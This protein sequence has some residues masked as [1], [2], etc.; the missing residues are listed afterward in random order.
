MVV[1]P[2][3]TLDNLDGDAAVL[4]LAEP[5]YT[6]TPAVDGTSSIAPLPLI[7]AA[8]AATFADPEGSAE[9]KISG[10]GDRTP[11]NGSG[12][13]TILGGSTSD[14]PRDLQTA[15]THVYKRST[16]AQTFVGTGA[17]VN[18]RVLCAGEP[19]G[20]IDSCQGDSGGPLTVVANGRTVLA[21]IVS[22][23]IGCAQPGRPGL[24]TRIAESSVNQFLRAA[25]NIPPDATATPPATTPTSGTTDTARPTMKL[26]S[27][28]CTATRCV[29]RVTVR[30]ASPSAGIRSLS[31]TLRSK[32]RGRTVTKK[33]KARVTSSGRGT[34]VTSG[35]VKRRRYTL[36]LRATDKAGLAQRRAKVYAIYPGR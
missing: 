8:E 22:L 2:G 5:L 15:T 28:K 7:T 30:D 14:Y 17:T 11:Q 19:G 23:G 24:Y 12:V 4:T 35:L 20:G 31:A 34:I 36:T 21:G 16:C 3:F 33:V 18:D 1:R 29:T 26:G 6:G 32:D 10:W 9:V 13:G 25:S 27:R